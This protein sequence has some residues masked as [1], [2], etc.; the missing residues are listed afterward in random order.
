MTSHIS[1]VM[2]FLT[3]SLHKNCQNDV[4]LLETWWFWPIL[5]KVERAELSC[6]VIKKKLL[7]VSYKIL[8]LT[9][10]KGFKNVSNYSLSQSQGRHGRQSS[11]QC[12]VLG[13]ILRNRKQWWQSRCT[14]EVAATLASLPAKNLPWQSWKLWVARIALILATSPWC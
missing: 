6:D 11:S 14:S 9:L 13:C 4:N 1:S 12:L 3:T 7:H 8:T 10:W 2:G 5:G